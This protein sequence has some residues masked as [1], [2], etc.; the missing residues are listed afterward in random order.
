MR[1]VSLLEVAEPELWAELAVVVDLDRYTLRVLDPTRREVDPSF[2]AEV[3]RLEAQGLPVLLRWAR[4]APEEV[5]RSTRGLAEVVATLAPSTRRVLARAQRHASDGGRRLYGRHA[6]DPEGDAEHVRRLLAAGL[7]ERH[8]EQAELYV[9]H[10]DLPPPPALAFDVADAV[11]D[12][13]D[14]LPPAKPGP[15][16]LLDDLASLAAAIEAVAPRRT[17]TGALA[18]ADAKRLCR[19][20]AIPD[21]SLDGEP[22]WGRA[23]RALDAL[24]AVTVDPLERT[25]HLDLG[26]EE[27][28]RGDA[29]DAVDHLVHRLIEQ[30]LH[31]V[32][33][34]VR[35]ALRQ[36]GTGAVDEVVLLELLREQHRDLVFHPW[37]RDGE[38]VYP[39]VE[40]ETPRP[41]DDRSFEEVEVPMIRAAL[42]RLD[43]LGLVRRAPGVLAATPDGRVWARV[44]ELQMPPVWA[45]GDLE[46]V[47]PP[48]GVSPWERMQIER[49]GTCVARDVV[50][51][52]KLDRKSLVAWLAAHDVDEAVELLRRRCAGLPP[53]V[54]AT[55]RAW[56]RSA[57]RVSLLR[58][59]V[60]RDA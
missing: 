1:A 41:F 52:Y 24:G 16:G 13:T 39:V 58:G 21:G 25:L 27:T 10:P 17:A 9:L 57:A 45:T 59:L 26:L 8:A 34:L 33:A 48:H 42:S 35:E 54:E 38:L 5:E 4:R 50:D 53:T 30:D 32:V 51:R 28:L 44:A 55:L 23:L 37:S 20:L 36:A 29:A 7:I 18:K 15:I 22:R 43:R 3:G 31:E 56:A 46:L 2:E 11:M 60:D 47:V 6:W 40:G 12:E 14:D 19:R 49:L